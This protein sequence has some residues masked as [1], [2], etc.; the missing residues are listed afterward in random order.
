MGEKNKIEEL[1]TKW[2]NGNANSEELEIL[3]EL[4]NSE[5][6][7][8]E[9]IDYLKK[10]WEDSETM[11]EEINSEKILEGIHR[12]IKTKNIQPS[13]IKKQ[14]NFRKIVFTGI[15]YAAIVLL[16]CVA[17]WYILNYSANEKNPKFSQTTLNEITVP[18]GSKSFIVLSDSTK[19]WLNAG[20]RLKYTSGFLADRREVFMEGE[21]YFE[22]SKNKAK[23]FFVNIAG[24]N[25]KV[26]GTQFNVRAYPDENSIE[27]TLI[28]GSIEI[29]GLKSDKKDEKDLQLKP[30]QKLILTREPTSSDFKITNAQIL[31]LH[32]TEAETAWMSDKLIFTKESFGEVLKKLERWY[33]VN[34]EI[35]NPEILK[36][37]FSGTFEEETFE[38]AL[39]ALQKAAKFDY[40]IKKKQV[41]VK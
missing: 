39:Q 28:E 9:I 30:G 36:Y 10:N 13:K 14:V 5:N 2:L 12:Q 32:S 24:M 29:V 22:V 35:E 37:R 4:F 31:N 1:V 18:Q 26:L 17:E 33:G 40:Q 7:A 21:A 8:K 19:V 23:P 3:F 38:Q 6:Q 27:T 41:T 15:R 11:E 34:I 20:A 16:A 25:I